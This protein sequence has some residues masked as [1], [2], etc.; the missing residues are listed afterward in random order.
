MKNKKIKA[1]W[2]WAALIAGTVAI[3]APCHSM[4]GQEEEE[5]KTPQQMITESHDKTLD[6]L[7]KNLENKIEALRELVSSTSN[8]NNNPGDHQFIITAL[9]AKNDLMKKTNTINEI[10]LELLNKFSSLQYGKKVFVDESQTIG[11]LLHFN[12]SINALQSSIDAL[13]NSTE[14]YSDRVANFM[15]SLQNANTAQQD[16]NT[17]LNTDLYYE[18][19]ES[20]EKKDD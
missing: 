19:I 17:D 16:L 13:I 15:T 12:E 11:P 8:P 10:E 18:T 1:S 4:Q 3:S 2:L 14:P 5:K 6:L 7:E 9:K 20:S